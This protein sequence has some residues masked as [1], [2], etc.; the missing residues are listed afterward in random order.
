LARE[1]EPEAEDDKGQEEGGYFP[2]LKESVE[3]AD[4]AIDAIDEAQAGV[5]RT[6]SL[7]ARRRFV[8]VRGQQQ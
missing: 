3:P 1:T 8:G 4:G 5:A 6:A 2:R 7:R